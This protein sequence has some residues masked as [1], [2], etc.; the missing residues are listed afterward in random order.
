MGA[1]AEYVSTVASQGSHVGKVHQFLRLLESVFQLKET[2]Y[3][4][5]QHVKSTRLQVR[6]RIDTVIGDVLFEFKTNL[7]KELG[8]AKGQLSKYLAVFHERPP[9]RPC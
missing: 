2:E 5:E 9:G 4:I 3:E 8:D 7:I 6:G 1:V